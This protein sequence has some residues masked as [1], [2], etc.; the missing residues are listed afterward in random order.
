MRG[1]LVGLLLLGFLNTTRGWAQDPSDDRVPTAKERARED[2][3]F[4]AFPAF[5][6]LDFTAKSAMQ[7]K[8]PLLGEVLK[9]PALRDAIEREGL[10]TL[11][12]RDLFFRAPESAGGVIRSFP[13][14]VT[15]KESRMTTDPNAD[16]A[17]DLVEVGGIAQANTNGDAI[18]FE[19]L[20][21]SA[22]ARVDVQNLNPPANLSEAN[23]QL[24]R[25][26]VKS[27]MEAYFRADPTRRQTLLGLD[28][29]PASPL[30]RL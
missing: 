17:T 8:D 29:R 16:D 18:E 1:L 6:I 5:P 19:V 27:T 30:E 21:L 9:S 25:E 24:L 22:H 7:A 28:T 15:V 11:Q 26:L 2:S 13:F 20:T 12:V 23:I 3:G 4:K 14:A 10:E